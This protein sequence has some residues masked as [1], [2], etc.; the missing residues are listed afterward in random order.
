MKKTI[1]RLARWDWKQAQA[2][3]WLA[4]LALVAAFPLHIESETITL[5]TYYPA[6]Y[7][8]YTQMRTTDKTTLAESGGAVGIAL[9]LNAEPD[10]AGGY[11]FDIG[12]KTRIRA[13]VKVDSGIN[14]GFGMDPGASPGSSATNMRVA[15]TG[16]MGATGYLY[17]AKTGNCSLRAENGTCSGGYGT[18]VPGLRT[19]GQWYAPFFNSPTWYFYTTSNPSATSPDY[20]WRRLNDI[21]TFSIQW[22]CCGT[23]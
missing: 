12:G 16:N 17:S 5:D 15:V 23:S 6:P 8:I 19:E 4:A 20:G 21:M 14:M 3:R 7:G 18:W 13:D 1:R 10:V 11:K 2:G 9:G 22:W